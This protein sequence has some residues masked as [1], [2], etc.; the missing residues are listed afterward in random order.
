M[1][2]LFVEES[3]DINWLSWVNN[4]INWSSWFVSV[5][6]LASCWASCGR[7]LG[8]ALLDDV[9][10]L[11]H[12]HWC[13]EIE[14]WNKFFTFGPG[15]ALSK[16][17][18]SSRVRSDAL[19]P[20]GNWSILRYLSWVAKLGWEHWSLS[21]L[22]SRVIS[23][24]S[25]SP[26]ASIVTFSNLGGREASLDQIN[27]G[28]KIHW[29]TEFTIWDEFFT[30]GPVATSSGGAGGGIF[31]IDTGSP[32]S[33]G[34]FLSN[35]DWVAEVLREQWSWGVA[36]LVS[37]V[38]SSVSPLA[39]SSTSGWSLSSNALLND[40]DVFGEV[41]WSAEVM[42]WDQFFTFRVDATGEFGA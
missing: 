2:E 31:L 40:L 32:D 20:L 19:S 42:I 36:G 29:G 13:T 7:V 1:A 33:L 17:A 5:D 12:V 41:H 30:G 3:W 28:G 4:W 38:G 6:P 27:V 34:S 14:V 24:S 8:E 22:V 35:I 25:L 23:G 9:N 18:F 39:V 26:L 10:I 11:G 37:N 16:R 21:T 15:A